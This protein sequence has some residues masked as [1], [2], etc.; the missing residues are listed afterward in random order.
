MSENKNMLLVKILNKEKKSHHREIHDYDANFTYSLRS[1]QIVQSN[2][3]S[4][5]K[6]P[7]D[8]KDIFTSTMLFSYILIYISV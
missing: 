4:Q 5:H 1:V 7:C 3:T 8:L 6:R 2:R